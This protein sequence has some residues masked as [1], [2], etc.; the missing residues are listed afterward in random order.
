MRSTLEE[1][2]RV[3]RELDRYLAHKGKGDRKMESTP[4]RNYE[5]VSV[6]LLNQFGEHFG[7]EVVE[8]KQKL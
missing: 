7:L 2:F 5:E 6:Y 3:K 4:W 1:L 8:G